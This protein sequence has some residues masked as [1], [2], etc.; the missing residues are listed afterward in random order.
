MYLCTGSMLM[1]DD[2]PELGWS[3]YVRVTSAALYRQPTSSTSPSIKLSIIN[4]DEHDLL[5]RWRHWRPG[6]CGSLYVQAEPSP[7]VRRGVP[8]NRVLDM[9][10]TGSGE[11]FNVRRSNPPTL[12][13]NSTNTTI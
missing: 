12:P 7:R 4:Q 8:A 9:L 10:F 11:A 6:H 3:S 13:H 1:T 5:S 2:P